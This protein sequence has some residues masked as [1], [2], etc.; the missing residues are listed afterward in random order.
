MIS[1]VD[2][3]TGK[4]FILSELNGSYISLSYLENGHDIELV[5][6]WCLCMLHAGYHVVHSVANVLLIYVV[7]V[8]T[9]GT[10]LSVILAFLINM[11]CRTLSVIIRFC[12]TKVPSEL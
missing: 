12:S 5:H 1:L 10:R 3:R 8:T 11:V 7:L 2:V 6:V 9:A 4:V